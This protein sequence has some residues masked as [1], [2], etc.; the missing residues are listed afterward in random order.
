MNYP[1]EWNRRDYDRL[2]YLGTGDGLSF[3]R[4]AAKLH[5]QEWQCIRIETVGMSVC[6]CGLTNIFLSFFFFVSLLLLFA[7]AIQCL[8]H[9]RNEIVHFNPFL[10]FWLVIVLVLFVASVCIVYDQ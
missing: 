5:A 1:S 7:V 10:A 3:Y 9:A 4:M 8:L 2:F 6:V